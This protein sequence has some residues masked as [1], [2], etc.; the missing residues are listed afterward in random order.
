M[1]RERERERERERGE[2]ER[3][4][5]AD[6]EAEPERFR[7]YHPGMQSRDGYWKSMDVVNRILC[8][9]SRGKS[10][11]LAAPGACLLS[12]SRRSLLVVLVLGN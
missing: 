8:M 10:I 9:L 5:L 2:R 6:R 3:E 4:R 12:A 7:E 1:Q 11:A